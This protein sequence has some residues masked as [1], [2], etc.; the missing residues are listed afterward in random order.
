LLSF[1]ENP[2]HV[3]LIELQ[4]RTASR[5]YAPAF[6]LVGLAT[7]GLAMPGITWHWLP[8]VARTGCFMCMK[9]MDAVALA[10]IRI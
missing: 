9:N 6:G 3:T 5:T 4:E 2:V 10:I 8:I 1:T 7:A